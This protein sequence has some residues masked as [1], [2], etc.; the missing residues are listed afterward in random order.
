MYSIWPGKIVSVGSLKLSHIELYC[1]SKITKF[2][3]SNIATQLDLEPL[4][5]AF[6]NSLSLGS[7]RTN[8]LLLFYVSVEPCGAGSLP[9]ADQNMVWSF[10]LVNQTASK[11]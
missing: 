1:S 8:A 2:P 3:L 4:P 7:L 9:F 5:G 6:H 10:V 11:N